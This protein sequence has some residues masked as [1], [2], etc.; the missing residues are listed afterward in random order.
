MAM[1]QPTL[2]HC[3]EIRIRSSIGLIK[4]A[5]GV[6]PLHSEGET[7]LHWLMYLGVKLATYDG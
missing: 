6:N 7:V 3:I 2:K 5:G 4:I 1:L